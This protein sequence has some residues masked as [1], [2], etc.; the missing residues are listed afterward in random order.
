MLVKIWSQG[1]TAPFL[2]G[3]QTCT[4][5]LK[6]NLF[7]SQKAGDSFLSQD[8]VIP[9][10]PGHITKICATTLQRHLLNYVHSSFIYNNQKLKT[11]QMSL[12]LETIQIFFQ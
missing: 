11:T 1:N 9:Q 2:V 8:P 4:T 3:V 7:F 10:D 6:I 12:T 5:T